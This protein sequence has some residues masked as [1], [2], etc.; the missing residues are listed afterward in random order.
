MRKWVCEEDCTRER[1]VG[2]EKTRMSKNER[3]K[4]A[5]KVGENKRERD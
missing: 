1:E 4:R 2:R 5:R 3:G